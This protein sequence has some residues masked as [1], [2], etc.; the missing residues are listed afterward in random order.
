MEETKYCERSWRITPGG[1]Y[2]VV[3]VRHRLND[4]DEE[5]Y[6][7]ILLN[8]DRLLV[9]VHI[10]IVKLEI[11]RAVEWLNLFFFFIEFQMMKV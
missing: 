8:S 4:S 3:V 2:P 11:A 7:D 5:C 10:L 9:Q 1:M 6:R